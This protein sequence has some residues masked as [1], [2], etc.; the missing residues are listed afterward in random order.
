MLDAIHVPAERMKLVG[1]R[2]RKY[3]LGL[4]ILNQVAEGP[5]LL[6]RMAQL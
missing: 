3:A 5:F 6:T 1:L 2:V 4:G